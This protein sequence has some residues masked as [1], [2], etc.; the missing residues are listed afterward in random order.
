MGPGLGMLLLVSPSGDSIV[1]PGLTHSLGCQNS[2]E[3]QGGLWKGTPKST[4][5]LVKE[6]DMLRAK[7]V[8]ARVY[9]APGT[10]LSPHSCQEMAEGW[11]GRKWGQG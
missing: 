11:R 5:Q 2:Q 7:Q 6:V 8:G 4:G 10:K 9:A 3:D 1:Q